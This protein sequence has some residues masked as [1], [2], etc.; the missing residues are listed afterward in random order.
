MKRYLGVILASSMLAFT[1]S[2]VGRAGAAGL[3]LYIPQGAPS[4]QAMEAASNAALNYTVEGPAGIVPMLTSSGQ[5]VTLSIP[6][7]GFAATAFRDQLGNVIIGFQLAVTSPAQQLAYDI[8]GGANPA[9]CPG[10]QDA[11]SFTQTVVQMAA[12]QGV[13]ASK[14]YV[15]GFSLGAMFASYVSLTTGL[16]GVGFGSS[17]L[18][19][20]QAPATQAGNF[21]SFVE[22]GDPVAQYGTDTSEAGS[23]VVASLHMD[24]YGT[25]I[26]LGTPGDAAVLRPFATEI[27]GY[28][29]LELQEGLIPASQAQ[30]D[31]VKQQEADL[32]GRYHAMVVYGPDAEALAAA[33]GLQ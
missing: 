20:Y 14:L 15:T 16:P 2:G 23:A 17:G 24:H 1:A 33:Y 9:S 31:Q 11:L 8:V 4:L 26:E 32:Q 6:A 12:A 19:G 30:I 29:A 22:A 25:V 28:S 5:S 13:S 27:N 10:F 18:P 7:D 21:I 3:D